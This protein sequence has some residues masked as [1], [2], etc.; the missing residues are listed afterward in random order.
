MKTAI[1]TAA[2]ALFAFGVAQAEEL[3]PL[4]GKTIDLGGVK[5]AAYYTVEGEDFRVVTTLQA[6]ETG[7]PLRF[8]STLS[9]GE[10]LTV[11]VP[12]RNGG[13]TEDLMITRTGDVLDVSPKADL[14][15]AASLR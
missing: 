7:S 3:K 13:T 12:S 6:G 11:Q 10:T 2:I 5:G 8:V 1:A 14:R 4:A 15:A 9:D